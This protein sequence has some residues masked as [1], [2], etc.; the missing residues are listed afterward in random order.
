MAQ[1]AIAWLRNDLRVADN[2]ALMRAAEEGRKLV[3]LYVHETTSGIR[4]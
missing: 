2:P 4:W 3:A 1:T